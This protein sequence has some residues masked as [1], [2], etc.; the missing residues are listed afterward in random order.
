[1]SYSW[2][3]SLPYPSFQGFGI[4]ER[5]ELISQYD[6]KQGASFPNYAFDFAVLDLS[7]EQEDFDWSW[8]SARRDPALTIEQTERLAPTS[9]R[10]WGAEGAG[11]LPRVRRHVTKLMTTPVI[12][13]R[14][15]AGSRE[16]TAL[17]QIYAFYDGR[18]HRF[19]ILAA[20]VVGRILEE[21]GGAFMFGWVTRPSSDGG[22]DFIGRLDI[23]TGFSRVKQVVF[24][25]AKCENPE[26][27][28]SG[29]DIAR[30]VARL[31][32]GW[33]GAYVTLGAFSL[34]V[35]RE[36]IDDEY[37]ILLVSGDRVVREVLSA[38]MEAGASDIESYLR[39]VDE[40]YDFALIDRRP[41]Q[42]LR[43]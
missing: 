23:G 36:V 34:P 32:R 24:G 7:R 29:R 13:Q 37:P 26:S 18:K 31:R 42:I 43:Q 1:M 40:E 39:S 14:P 5:A 4:I 10:S 19:E 20:R 11:A 35:Q 21:S 41:E 28:T 3:H 38:A 15:P 22:A 16:A 9:W 2:P 17:R 27:T 6:I 8:V 25:Q 33:I 30:T 12:D